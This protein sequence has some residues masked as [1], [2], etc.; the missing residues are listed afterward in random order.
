MERKEEYNQLMEELENTPIQLEYTMQ[1]V[2]AR[3]RERYFKRFFAIPMSTCLMV[4]I[5]F[6]MLVNCVPVFA[7]TCGNIPIVKALAKLVAFSPSLSA[8]VENKYVQPI[9]QVQT[10]NGITAKIEYVIVD[11]KQ[12]NIIYSLDSAVYTAMDATPCITSTDGEEL[13]GYGISSGN[14]DKANG[15]L[16]YITVDFVDVDMPSSLNFT[17]KVHD[18]GSAIKESFVKEDM[19]SRENV[20]KAPQDISTFTF[21]LEFNPYYT[22]QGETIQI[23][24]PFKLDGEDLILEQAEIYPTHM[25]LTFEDVESNTAWIRSLEFYIENEKGKKFDKIAN[26]ISA[27]GK[28]DSPMMASHRLESSFFTESKAL[29]MYITGVEWLDKDRQ[30]IKLDLKNVKAEGLPDNVVFEQA[31]RKE[32]G[33]LLTFGGQEYEE[34]VSYQIWQSNY[35]DEDGKEYYFNS[36][37]SGMS[38]YWDEEKYI[39][40]PGVFHVEIPLV[41]YPYDTV[42]MTPNFTRNVKLDEPVVITIK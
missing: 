30:K 9:E 4:L 3:R 22:A 29:T 8:A 21:K 7:Y 32:K 27:T 38:G 28:I 6:T 13:G 25:S 36:W 34:D 17:L 33:W 41:D 16:N 12:L 39:E 19:F 23:N 11:Q 14:S 1:R 2:E 24:Q 37:S 5:A 15:A 26:G 10:L 40:T 35:Y 31:Q 20:F 18:N 42:Y